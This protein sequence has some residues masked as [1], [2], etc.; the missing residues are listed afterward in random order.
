[1]TKTRGLTSETSWQGRLKKWLLPTHCMRAFGLVTSHWCRLGSGQSVS[2][3]FRA[4]PRHIYMHTAFH[5]HS[6]IEDEDFPGIMIV[7]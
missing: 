1:M 4:H 3:L 7:T 6:R 5:T 2:Q